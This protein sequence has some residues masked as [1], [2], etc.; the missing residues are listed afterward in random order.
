MQVHAI[1]VLAI[2]FNENLLHRNLYMNV[3]GSLL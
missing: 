2:Y 3:C 1:T